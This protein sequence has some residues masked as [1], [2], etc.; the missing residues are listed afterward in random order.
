MG[1]IASDPPGRTKTSAAK[2]FDAHFV[3]SPAAHA[4]VPPVLILGADASSTEGDTL[5]LIASPTTAPR[6]ARSLGHPDVLAAKLRNK[7]YYQSMRSYLVESRDFVVVC[8]DADLIEQ[9][10]TESDMQASYVKLKRSLPHLMFSVIRLSDPF[11][12]M[13]CAVVTAV[14]TRQPIFGCQPAPAWLFRTPN[15]SSR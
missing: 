15:Y 1:G 9:C 8:A 10:E 7:E 6:V 11:I 12:Y 2:V 3:P 14:L 5:R 4:G 13:R